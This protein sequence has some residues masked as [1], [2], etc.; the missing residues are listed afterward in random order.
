MN[1]NIK[2]EEMINEILATYEIRVEKVSIGSDSPVIMHSVYAKDG[3][4][5]G[6]VEDAQ[7]Y[8]EMGI[9][10]EK[11]SPEHKV[12]SIGKSLKDG[13]WYGWSHRAIYGFKI[14]DV[15]K[16]GDLVTQSGYVEEYAKE[17]P[18]LDRTVP[19]GFEAK[20]EEDAKKM[21]IAFADSVA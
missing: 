6:D 9:L 12:C 4:Y 5:V 11:S 17:H 15:A 16:D 21:A 18:E 1:E 8:F 10:P 19:V 3:G 13:K 2:S 7:K 20:T 14:G